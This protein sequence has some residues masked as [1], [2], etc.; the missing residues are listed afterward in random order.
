MKKLRTFGVVAVSAVALSSCATIVEGNSQAINLTT[1]VKKP[2][3]MCN[4]KNGVGAWTSK[5][6]PSTVSVSK[7]R[8]DMNITCYSGSKDLVAEGVVKSKFA[9][10]ALGNIILGG[11]IGLGVDAGS[12]AMFK[13]PAQVDIGASAV[14]SDK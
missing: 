4:L 3:D 7:S 8:S 11:F 2:I 5:G 12:G 9:P 13:Y 1:K 10:W 14:T 6:L